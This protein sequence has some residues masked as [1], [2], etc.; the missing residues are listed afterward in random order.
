[1]QRIP[2]VAAWV[3]L[4]SAAAAPA[5][6]PLDKIYTLIDTKATEKQVTLERIW[7]H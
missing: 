2:Q 5:Q 1:M 7:T 4:S 3:S 6:T